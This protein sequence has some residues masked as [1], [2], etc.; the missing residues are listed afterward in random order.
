MMENTNQILFSWETEFS[1]VQRAAETEKVSLARKCLVVNFRFQSKQRRNTT[2][3][4]Y[5]SI[6]LRFHSSTGSL[7]LTLI[8]KLEAGNSMLNVKFWFIPLCK[9]CSYILLKLACPTIKKKL[10]H[11]SFTFHF[12]FRFSVKSDSC[13]AFTSNLYISLLCQQLGRKYL[14][15]V[16]TISKIF[17]KNITNHCQQFGGKYLK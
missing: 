4:V 12:W 2:K 1:V 14:K 9:S 10:K 13:Q 8:L 7:W 16:P 5:F 6:F 11:V 3:S 15:S 17:A